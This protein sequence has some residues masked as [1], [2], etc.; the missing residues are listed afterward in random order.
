MPSSVSE[1]S[2][3]MSLRMRRYSSG[4]RPCAATSAGVILPPAGLRFCGFE[5]FLA[6]GLRGADF[7]ATAFFTADFFR[8]LAFWAVGRFLRALNVIGP[9]CHRPPQRG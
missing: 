4:L 3:P 9:K 5:V 7:L 6:G 2:R 8:A 1:G